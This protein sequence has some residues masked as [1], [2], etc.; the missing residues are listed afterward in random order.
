MARTADDTWDLASSVGAT[1]T[2][3]AAAR[4]MATNAADPVIDDPF[5]APLVRAV[6]LAF[7]TKLVDD[8]FDVEA[9]DEEAKTGLTRFA[10]GM[11]ARTRFFDDFF[12]DAGRA[13]IRQ[14]VILASGLDS[15]AYRLPWPD[16]T[17]VYEIDQPE[18]IE[19]KTATLASLGAAP[20]TDRRAVAMDLRF[21]WPAALA[22]AG[23]DP[24]EPTAWI[25][26]GL[27]GYLP[28]EAQ[29]SLL[30]QIT[31]LSA[32]GSRLGVEGVPATEANDEESI[33][34][35]MKDFTDRWRAH[36]LD[37]DLNELIFL[38]D[39]ADVTTYLEGH[40]WRT[41][42]ISSND[43]LVRTGLPPVEDEAHAASVMYIS[44]EK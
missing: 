30:D 33:R 43:L 28:P 10:N 24:A 35:R 11:A 31:A 25:A 18:V 26:E 3:V 12:L 27:L 23:F 14:A 21:D 1:A 5:A 40:D 44:A 29:D 41:T 19:F 34:A 8:T 22:E 37:I 15:R 9:L 6:G 42:G 32:P 20:T 39:R 7:F 38:G 17:V 4:A 36:G 16:G 2:M 13:G